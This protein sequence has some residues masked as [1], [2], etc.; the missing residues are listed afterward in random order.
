[1]HEERERLTIVR[2]PASILI[3]LLSLAIASSALGQQKAG[4]ERGFKPGE[5][6]QFNGF[7]SVN[8]FSGNL[9]LTVPLGQTYPV[10]NG[11][12]Y[13]FVLRYSGNIWHY[14]EWMRPWTHIT[15]PEDGPQCYEAGNI[16]ICQVAGCYGPSGLTCPVNPTFFLDSDSGDENRTFYFPIRA[17]AGVGWSLSFGE[18]FP[19][20]DL[21]LPTLYSMWRY[22]SPDG[23][24][25]G[26]F[27][28]LHDPPCPSSGDHSSGD[29]DPVVAG[30]GYTRDGTY[31]RIQNGLSANDR[32]VELADGRKQL[33]HCDLGAGACQLRYLYNATSALNAAGEPTTNFVKF[34]FDEAKNWIITDS[35]GRVHHVLFQ[36]PEP[37]VGLNRVIDKVRLEA[38]GG[39]TAEY[40]LTYDAFTNP[41]S[42]TDGDIS[43]IERP[44]GASTTT[45][46]RVRLLTRVGLPSGESYV[47]NYQHPAVDG[48]CDDTSG[49]L[50]EAILPTLGKLTWSYQPYPVNTSYA[51]TGVLERKSFDAA[52][53]VLQRTSYT[54]DLGKTTV[55]TLTTAG[56]V[57]TRT[58]NYFQSDYGKDHGLPFTTASGTGDG[59][60]RYLSTET[61]DGSC[62]VNHKVR[63]TYVKYESDW[64]KD[65]CG[66]DFPCFRDR[67][68]RVVSERTS[69]LQDSKHA[70]AAFSQF[71]G[72]GHYRQADFDGNYTRGN[73]RQT[74][75]SFN[76]GLGNYELNSD[77]TR[78][79]TGYT[80]FNAIKPWI[81][82]TY[83]SSYTE[84]GTLQTGYFHSLIEAC[85]DPTGFL[86]RTRTLGSNAGTRKASDLLTVFTKD[87]A[88]GYAGSEE[89]FGGDKQTISTDKSICDVVPPAHNPYSYQ[90]DHTYQYGVLKTSRYAGMDKTFYTVNNTDIDKSTGAVTKSEDPSKLITN[91]SYDTSGRLR[92]VTPPGGAAV[93]TYDFAKA[94]GTEPARITVTTGA[95]TSDNRTEQQ[96]EFDGLGRLW[97]EKRRMPDNTTSVRETLFDFAGRNQSV[98]EWETWTGA[99]PTKKT[100]FSGYDSLG[101]VGTV[102]APDNKATMFSY[103]GNRQTTRTNKVATA[104]GAETS[105]AVAEELDRFGRLFTVTEDA[106]NTSQKTEYYYRVGDQL[107]KVAMSDQTRTFTIDGRGLL[108]SENHPE[109][110]KTEY[111]Y[112]ARGHVVKKTT[113]V[114][115][116][117]FEYDKAERLKTVTDALA[118][119]TLKSFEYD[120]PDVNLGRL[121]KQTRN[122][123]LSSGNYAIADAFEYD[124]AGRASKKTTTITDPA[125]ATKTFE[126]NYAYT[127][128]SQPSFLKY[129]TCSNCTPA[130]GTSMP[131]QRDIELSYRSGLLTSVNGVTAPI[132][133]NDPVQPTAGITY[134]P[135]GQIHEVL[136]GSNVRDTFEPDDSGIARPKR[137]KFTN[138]ID[139]PLITSQSADKQIGIGETATFT[140]NAVSGTT[141]I[142]YRGLPGDMSNPAGSTAAS[143]TTPQLDQTTTYWCL[144]AG[145]TCS[146]NSRVFTATVCVP[147]ISSP[148][149]DFT[150][151]AMP[152]EEISS[153]ILAVA[154][155]GAGWSYKWEQVAV[156]V[157]T[158]GV[159]SRAGD[160]TVL[161]SAD[162]VLTWTAP[163]YNASSNR[164]G[165]YV[166]V[167]GSC[168]SVSRLVRVFDVHLRTECTAPAAREIQPPAIFSSSVTLSILSMPSDNNAVTFLW[169]E[170][171]DMTK[172]AGS[173]LSIN[174]SPTTTT[175]YWVRMI[176]T[177]EF[178]SAFTDTP[179]IDVAPPVA[180]SIQRIIGYDKFGSIYASGD[181]V[182]L[183]VDMDPPASA[184]H[185]YKYEWYRDDASGSTKLPGNDWTIYV[186]T[187]SLNT[188]WVKVTGTYTDAGGA[189][190]DE[191]SISPKMYVS[192]YG[193]CALPPVHVTQ[194][195]ENIASGSPDITFVAVCDWL[196]TRF[197]WYRG[198]SGDTREP[199]TAKAGPDNQLTVGT[200]T[201][202][203]YWVRVSR[204]DCDAYVDSPTLSFTRDTCGP[205][206]INPNVSSVDVAYD[207]T[208]FLTVEPPGFSAPRYKWY[209]EAGTA[210]IPDATAPTLELKN[211]R[212]S[213][214]YWVHINDANCDRSEGVDSFLATVR[215]ASCPSIAPPQ[216]AT[217]VWV[218]KNSS[219]T[220]SAQSGGATSYQW[221]SGEVG[222]KRFPIGGATL[223]TYMTPALTAETKYWVRVSNGNCLVD[224]PTITVKVCDPPHVSGLFSL[225]ETIEP[226]QW[227]TF[228]IPMEGTDLSYQW[229]EGLPGDTSLPRGRSINR[230]QV[231]PTVTTNYWLRVTGHCGVGGTNP[232]IYETPLPFTAVVCPVLQPPAVTQPIVM[233]RAKTTLSIVAQ[234]EHLA[235]QW[236][237]GHSGDKSAPV[238]SGAS[239]SITT[240]EILQETTFWCEVTGEG[241]C[242][243]N[244]SEVT[245]QLCNVP[246][247]AW[248]GQIQTDAQPN[249][250]QAL[251]IIVGDPGVPYTL[252][253]YEGQSG[254]V[255]GSQVLTVGGYTAF[256]VQP[257]TTKSYWVRMMLE[258]G[259]CYSDSPTLTIRVCVPR[260]TAE[261]VGPAGVIAPG[262]S[263]TLTVG[264]STLAGQTFQWYVGSSGTTSTPVENATNATLTIAPTV[265]T[266]Y[267]VRVTGSCGYKNSAAATITV[268][269]PPVIGSVSQTQFIAAG[270]NATI[271]VNA[272]GANRT[273][274][275]YT[276]A[277]GTTTSPVVNG[278]TSA[279]TVS[280]A[281]TTNYWAEVRSDG[282]CAANSPAVTVNV[283]TTPAFSVQPQSQPMFAGKTVTLTAAA[284]SPSG[285]VTY[286]WYQGTAGTMT[287]PINGETSASLTVSPAAETSY[288]VRATTSVCT[289]DSNTATISI[290]LYPDIVDGNPSEKLI[291][292]S[293]STSI[294]LPPL[295]PV[296]DKYVTWY[297]G[298]SGDKSANLGGA[299][300][301]NTYGTPA[302]TATTQYWAEFTNG[303]CISKTNT[304]TVRVCKPTINT[305]PAGS[306]IQSGQSAPL[307]VGTTP[308]IGQTFQWYTGTPGTT[309]SP[310][311][312]GTSSSISV[313]PT[314]TTSYWV[315][316]TGTCGVVADSAAATITVCTPP[317]ISG[318]SPTRY[319]ESGTS[320]S[321]SVTA[322][323]SSLTYQWYAG[324]SGV[325]SSPIQSAT[326]SSAI[327]S[328]TITTTYWCRITSSGLC[329]I[330]GPTLTVDVCNKPAITTQPQSSRVFYAKPTT[331][332]VAATSPRPLSY[333]WYVG[334]SGDIANPINTATSSSVTVAPTVETSYWVRVTTSVCS[335]DSAA[336]TLSIC[337]YP[338]VLTPSPAQYNIA[339][340]QNATLSLPPLSPV[341]DKTVSWY[342]GAS[343]DKSQL[344]ASSLNLSSYTTPALT[345]TT[346]Y[347]AEFTNNT[348]VSRTTTYT[349]SVC[350]P[351]ITAQPQSTTVASG[352]QTTLSVTATGA[353]LTYQWYIGSSGT[354][355]SPINGATASSYTTPALTAA[356]TYWVRLTGCTTA[357]SAS[358]TVSICTPPSV[359]G[360]TK[361]ASRAIGSSGSVTVTATGTGLTYQW[362]KGQSGDATRIVSGATSATYTFSLQTSEYYWVKVTSP[363]NGASVNSAAIM[364]S[365]DPTIT[366]QPQSVTVRSGTPATLSVQANGTY[367]SYAWY[368]TNSPN[369][370]SGATSATFITPPLTTQTIYYCTVTSGTTAVVYSS[371]A[372]VSICV[373]P[374]IDNF[375][376]QYLGG[377]SWRFTVTVPAPDDANVKYYW[378]RGAAGNVAQS[379]FIGEGGT[380]LNA[381]SPSQPTT[382]WA[383]VWWLD[384]S[385][386][387]DTVGS[388]IP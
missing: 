211:V 191:I 313:S 11:L 244:S 231:H 388:T 304:Y 87:A 78:K 302:L 88:S 27:N 50:T 334:A 20:R 21:P 298:A 187:N 371:S 59:T 55:D 354:T 321:V 292:Y 192:V 252:T 312:N 172:S 361:T 248:S 29:C 224:S 364:Y 56:T 40:D 339:S 42:T 310:V 144:V 101:R 60:G 236:Y 373:G 64:V 153:T 288:W 5:S 158:N 377:G 157:D 124:T 176:R 213:A 370:I 200:F 168:T 357:D 155:N 251:N 359:S 117:S 230:L 49:T 307:S 167:T 347:W 107:S 239:A 245:V 216:W 118:S 98:S 385:C 317:G 225:K 338:E 102:T 264:T 112:D 290:C 36:Q 146:R 237:I 7:D 17:N 149:Q 253:W 303:G 379:T 291:A 115:Q 195:I 18:L 63:A 320:T 111:L 329:T 104:V 308:I 3:L 92:S 85:F 265:T 15:P 387:T 278:N 346:Q 145:P 160:P 219:I 358:T 241:G 61:C 295:S 284:S 81:L 360:L 140:V 194:S 233:Y 222:D 89:F 274:K 279:I 271:A 306:T 294:S 74:Y 327:V 375:M 126:Q 221:Y 204:D 108:T 154:V 215:V 45:L 150:G 136:H 12:S 142:W 198:Q 123:Y 323:G 48:N 199:I 34:E 31:M 367:L 293:T 316:V 205:V 94:S 285:A 325:T 232:R 35:H 283:C 9:N 82:G 344:L 91:Y 240:P 202:R 8:L 218:D 152:V 382:Y 203:P 269:S 24:E 175:R 116:L 249:Q 38:I 180:A 280:P 353:P 125:L 109:S 164:Y 337:S 299:L 246:A 378:Y 137:I 80:M 143:F 183:F 69:F 256:G 254:N 341:E 148:P 227:I 185:K 57:E 384:D 257:A 309:T 79:N 319:I 19:A 106:G 356:T 90:I 99:S 151:T 147:K 72:L 343:G 250:Y 383:R 333:Q 348:C 41:N 84:E 315:R 336:A 342:R 100:I 39:A 43:R 173:G 67:N 366:A 189:R 296:A 352:G 133:P 96:F 201:I 127:E 289:A 110:N 14:N 386:Y 70:D 141:F 207:A 4:R 331:L 277:S 260:I 267:W 23:G 196:H 51:S 32:I 130:P 161:A 114:A 30:V 16:L 268:C 349:V 374:T 368:S 330:N 365:V 332:S 340:G 178:K 53:H 345:A 86:T 322:T 217:E 188:F 58:V 25:H 355:T 37:F 266:T 13:S 95:A 238:P 282:F 261:P 206:L 255:S 77:G 159:W 184:T 197:Q 170:G 270:A 235:Y 135:A 210:P 369:P 177:C 1:V 129:P 10:A 186:T 381:A 318:T 171:S 97:R 71:D 65:D 119:K 229:Y 214:R 300:N 128:L 68:P 247:I 22:R 220:L 242:A 311:S 138:A 54:A 326:A 156:V 46:A 2:F 276:G 324:A 208:A 234:G 182:Q 209:K 120:T 273:Y 162:S 26:F 165:L 28:T 52:N 363:C 44:C 372:T 380:Y 121:V 286:Q 33:F 103:E 181:P 105:V 362:Y 376:R 262:T 263:T 66:I 335:I 301:L 122:N 258:N 113:P 272:T 163:P 131:G 243:R 174:V 6:Y 287:T 351:T 297:R 228:G 62:D 134:S 190:H 83:N 75:T 259:I 350:K 73:Q 93:T 193:V 281:T 76:L 275:W 305:Q 328:P 166:T 314:T 47:F 139:C 226:G 212:E 179:P 132:A 169:F 223:A